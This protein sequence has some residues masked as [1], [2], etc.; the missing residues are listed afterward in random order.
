VSLTGWLH[1]AI[2]AAAFGCLGVLLRLARADWRKPGEPR[3]PVIG[4]T[5]GVAAI[6]GALAWVLWVLVDAL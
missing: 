4:A 2:T 3:G 1:L 6:I 5:I